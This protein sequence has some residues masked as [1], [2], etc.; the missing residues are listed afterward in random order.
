MRLNHIDLH[1]PDVASTRDFLINFFGLRLVETRGVD[2]LAILEDDSGLEIVIS[3][4]V[5][6]LGG[7]DAVM[8][9]VNT[10]HIGFI[11]PNREA[12]DAQYERLLRAGA[13]ISGAPR[14]IRGGWLFYCS[15][16]GRILVEVGC[17]Q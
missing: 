2:G 5:A 11:L 6:K 16:P 9:G 17:R 8:A 10:F 1:T 14:E 12:V 13:D 4:P 7:S 15:A 3:R